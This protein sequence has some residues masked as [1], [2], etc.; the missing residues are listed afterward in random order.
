MR[1]R[2]SRFSQNCFAAA[3]AL[4]IFPL[5]AGAQSAPDRSQFTHKYSLGFF[6]EGAPTSSH[7]LLGIARK[8]ELIGGG[9][10]LTW[11]LFDRHSVELD[12]LGEVRP[13]L[14]ESDPTVVS[15]YS[16]RYGNVILFPIPIPVWNPGNLAFRYN[17]GVAPYAANGYSNA[18]F[19]RRWT[20]TGGASPFG[21]QLNALKRRRLQPEAMVNAGF[22][23]ST[24]EIPVL[25]SSYFNF[26]FQFG[27]GIEWYRTARQSLLLEYR[28]QHFSNGHLGTYNPGTDAGLWK[29]TYRFGRR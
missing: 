9:A 10:A 16:D 13:L 1:E 5:I 27:G 24:R 29:L 11:R 12:Y 25:Q 20:Y 19:S 15:F 18:K 7:I 23:V 21:F 2:A 6:A 26:E 22:L 3:L 14:M 4:L 8:R 17:T 28:V